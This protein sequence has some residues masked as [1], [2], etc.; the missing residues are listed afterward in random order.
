MWK[1]DA[2]WRTRPTKTYLGQ[3]R[4]YS[5]VGEGDDGPA[6]PDGERQPKMNKKW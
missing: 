5:L 2:D 1:R 4:D 6:D 3:V